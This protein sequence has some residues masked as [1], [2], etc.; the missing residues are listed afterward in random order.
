MKGREKDC[1]SFTDAGKANYFPQALGHIIFNVSVHNT[2]MS[3]DATNTRLQAM[4]VDYFKHY[5]GVP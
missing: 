2:E 3:P 4:A 1:S 5:D